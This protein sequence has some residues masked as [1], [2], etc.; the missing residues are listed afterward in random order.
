MAYYSLVQRGFIYSQEWQNQY[1]FYS[2]DLGD[3]AGGAEDLVGEFLTEIDFPLVS[4]WKSNP[5][6]FTRN[7]IYAVDI[8]NDDDFFEFLFDPGSTGGNA[9]SG[10]AVSP[11]VTYSFRTARWRVKRNRGYKRYSGICE[12]DVSGNL[13]NPGGTVIEDIAT[14]LSQVLIGGTDVYTP[15]IAGKEEYTPDPEEPL[16]KA[17]RYYASEAT[18]RLESSQGADWDGYRLTTQRSRIQGQGV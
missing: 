5:A 2:A 17:Y 15:S 8:F 18:Q 14:A 7:S 3:V 6:E 1:N 10:A 13:F 12:D 9:D 4:M 16:K 11:F